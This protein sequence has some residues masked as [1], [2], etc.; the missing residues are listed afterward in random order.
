MQAIGLAIIVVERPRTASL[1]LLLLFTG[2]FLS[3]L[4][5][6]SHK[7]F[8]ATLK[9]IPLVLAPVMALLGILMTL[10]MPLRDPTLSKKGISPVF[11]PS[12]VELRTPEDDLTPWQ[13]MV[14]SWMEPLIRKGVKREMNDEDVWDLGWEFKHARLHEAFRKLRGSVT[15]RIFVANG[16]DLVRT[17]TIN[18]VRLVTSK[19]TI[20]LVELICTDAYSP[21]RTSSP[22]TSIS[23]NE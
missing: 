1:S 14:V 19:R 15:R 16:M 2:L 4:V 5:M 10:N 20:R 7:P 22:S 8:S 12:T 17:T 3:Q 23:V 18:V 13:Y 6:L 9:D 11:S 21:P